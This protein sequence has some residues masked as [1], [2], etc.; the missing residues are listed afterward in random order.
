MTDY[1]ATIRMDAADVHAALAWQSRTGLKMNMVYNM[2]GVE[3]E[4]YGQDALFDRVPDGE[5][6]VPLDQPHVP[7]PEPRLHD[8]GVHAAPDHATTRP[9]STRSRPGRRGPQRPERGGHRRALRAGERPAGQPGDDRSAGLR[10]AHADDRARSPPG[11]TT[12]RSPPRRPPARP[13]RRSRTT[14]RARPRTAASSR[15][16]PRSATRP[17]STLYRA[18]HRPAAWEKVATLAR[19]DPRAARS[20][21]APRR[22]SLSIDRR[23]RARAA[24]ARRRRPTARRSRRTSQNDGLRPRARRR[25][26][27]HRRQRLVQAVPEPAGQGP[28][29]S[30]SDPTNFPK[31]ASFPLGPALRAVPRYPSNVYYNVANRADQLDEYNWIYLAPPARAASARPPRVT[32]C[33]TR[34]RPG[35]STSTARRGSCSA[36]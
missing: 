33:R 5:E 9:A 27:P 8:Q 15:R 29:L 36:T 1:D 16:S 2:G 3:P 10:R 32:T 11:R 22:W 4:H 7:A 6:R 25:G 19:P 13:L 35:R 26:H 17:A 21:T 20:T 18:A 14:A 12:T 34:R 23:R 30:E 28:P 24:P 31:G